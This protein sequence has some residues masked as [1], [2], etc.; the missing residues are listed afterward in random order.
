MCVCV[1]CGTGTELSCL[2]QEEL[3]PQPVPAACGVIPC[4]VGGWWE[5]GCA[6]DKLP[7]PHAASSVGHSLAPAGSFARAQRAQRPFPEQGAGLNPGNGCRG[8]SQPPPGDLQPLRV[9]R[10]GSALLP[11]V[12]SAG[13]GTAAGGPWGTQRCSSLGIIPDHPCRGGT[14]VQQ[15]WGLSEWG[16]SVTPGF[17]GG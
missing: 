14:D 1:V 12:I 17:E 5:W 11:A 15:P 7:C 4:V 10:P 8:T 3:P 2:H 9:G 6:G 16:L 13:G